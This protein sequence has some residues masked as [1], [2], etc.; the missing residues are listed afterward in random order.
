MAAVAASASDGI[1]AQPLIH[2]SGTPD[3]AWR[4]WP[5]WDALAATDDTALVPAG[6]RA[7]IVAPHPDD[8]VLACGGL[9]RRLA[10]RGADVLVVAVSDGTASHPGSRRWPVWRLAA[11]RPRETQSALRVLG[12][13]GSAHARV[14]RAGLPDGAIR[15]HTDRL[16]GLLQRLLNPHDVVF[17]TWRH[18]G[19][20]DHDATGDATAQAAQRA[21]ARLV[22]VAVWAWHWAAPGDA[23]LPW[24]RAQQLRLSPEEVR[25]KSR[26]MREFRSQIDPDPSTGNAPIL[27]ATAL[28]RA[29][30]PREIYF[31]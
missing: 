9:L 8:E 25:A 28:Q 4:N 1:P 10:A 23:R 22:E 16:Q 20:P 24:A 5:G 13:S 15:Q 7:V 27:G 26:A 18:D 3:S 31:T 17:T 19:H 2:G 12:L 29:A 11:E 6:A 21:S 14:V 30:W